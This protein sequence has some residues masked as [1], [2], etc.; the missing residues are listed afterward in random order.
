MTKKMVESQPIDTAIQDA[1]ED[2]DIS[3]RVTLMNIRSVKRKLL[4]V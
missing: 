3:K 2:A 4:E 1:Y